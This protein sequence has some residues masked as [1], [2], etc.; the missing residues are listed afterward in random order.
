[1]GLSSDVMIGTVLENWRQLASGFLYVGRRSSAVSNQGG[2][3]SPGWGDDPWQIVRL[4]NCDLPVRPSSF[5]FKVEN[6]THVT[7]SGYAGDMEKFLQDHPDFVRMKLTHP[8]HHPDYQRFRNRLTRITSSAVAEGAFVS[9]VTTRFET[10]L[11]DDYWHDWLVTPVDFVRA[12]QTINDRYADDHIDFIEIGFHPV[13]EKC[14]EIFRD[15]T[16]VSSM[17]RGEDDIAWILYQRKKLDQRD[18]LE[19]LKKTIAAFKPELDFMTPLAYQ[20][21]LFRICRAVD[22]IA[23]VFS[24]PRP[25]GFLPFKTINQLIDR[26]WR[27]DG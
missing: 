14:C 24:I 12:M 8:W 7:L 26:F 4:S 2:G 15:Y 6:G 23:G 25:T 18:F 17:F 19:K 3:L 27:K 20:A 5:N 9:G 21:W 16:Y 1:M 10:R 13:L 11:D 22:T